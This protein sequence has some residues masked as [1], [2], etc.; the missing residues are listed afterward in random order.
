MR[1][2]AVTS[3][4]CAGLLLLASACRPGASSLTQ[5][6][7]DAADALA[8]KTGAP[9]EKSEMPPASDPAVRAFEE[10]SGRA[11]TALGTDAL[12]VNGFESFDLL[13][14][15]TA[16]IVAAYAMAGTRGL[17]GAEQQQR[18]TANVE[19]HLDQMFTPLLFS[20]HCT[21]Q[22]LP[23]FE[24]NIDASDSARMQSVKT[25]RDGVSQQLTGLMQM[26]SDPSL[27]TARRRR[28]MELIASDSGNFAIGLSAAQ[29]LQIFA[30]AGDLEGVLPDELRPQ[31]KQLSEKIA[32]TPCGRI[33]AAP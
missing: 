10:E 25:V 19:Q 3:C 11:L 20:A 21:A 2:R 26:A 18:M 30:A 27:G 16:K 8:A 7:S 33:C 4:T 5:S 29:R 31:V 32:R 13:C 12:P 1:W 6:F 24:S 14:A 23:F 17:A 22:H 28:V 9:A 15:K